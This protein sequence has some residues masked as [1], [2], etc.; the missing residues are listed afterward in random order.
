MMAARSGCSGPA[1]ARHARGD[2]GGPGAASRSRRAPVP[3]LAELAARLTERDRALCRLVWEHRVLTSDQIGRLV[4]NSP[5]TARHRLVILAGLRVLDR[6]RPPW[7]LGAGSA[8][9]H[10]VLGPAGAAVLAAEQGVTPAQLGYRPERA[11]SVAHSPRLAHQ[12]GVNGFFA[13]LAGYARRRA[14]AALITW[15]SE[16]QCTQRWGQV[17]RPDA[18]GRWRD[19]GLE[20][21][22]FLE[23]DRGTEELGRLLGKLDAYAEL[24]AV[25]EIPTP[26]LFWLPTATREASFRKATD[27]TAVSAATAVGL[28][29]A[30]PARAV[31]LPA[32]ASGP[33]VSLAALAISL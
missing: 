17:V 8:P 25:S 32:G 27:V 31:W 18:Y 21:D 28:P 13:A 20:V 23:Y 15:W 16:R 14:D 12:V 10:Y 24:G 3:D 30:H 5:I 2:R 11:L 33:R 22:F 29:G 4:F 9:W 26:V 19:G 1:T 6:F 7:E